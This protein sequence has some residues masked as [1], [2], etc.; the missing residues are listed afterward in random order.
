MED[1]IRYPS[2]QIA[3]KEI[4][5]VRARVTIIPTG[6]GGEDEG[7]KISVEFPAPRKLVENN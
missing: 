3:A 4:A 7:N 1:T 6:S 5:E 2:I